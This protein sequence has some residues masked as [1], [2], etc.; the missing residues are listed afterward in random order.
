MAAGGSLIA[1]RHRRSSASGD[2]QF[3]DLGTTEVVHPDPGEVI[4]VD[5]TGLVSARRWCWRQSEQSGSR[6]DTTEALITVEGHHTTAEQDVRS[7]L[8]DL[9]TLL[10]THV[11]GATLQADFPPITAFTAAPDRRYVF[12]NLT[13]QNKSSIIRNRVG[14]SAKWSWLLSYLNRCNGI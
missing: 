10:A 12:S 11:P 14:A 6:E 3:T 8:N 5:E 4:F 9:Q 1:R 7:A 2:E 13:I